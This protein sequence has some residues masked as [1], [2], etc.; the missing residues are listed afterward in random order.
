MVK[1][2]VSWALVGVFG[3]AWVFAGYWWS[4]IN[5]A[6]NDWTNTYAFFSLASLA[7][8]AR[9]PRAAGAGMFGRMIGTVRNFIPT[10]PWLVLAVLVARLV[11]W[12]HIGMSANPVDHFLHAVVA[13]LAAGIATCLWYAAIENATD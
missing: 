12:A 4:Y 11:A 3:Y 6:G 9:S 13:I 8:L 7:V 5:A 10:L 2:A 1:K